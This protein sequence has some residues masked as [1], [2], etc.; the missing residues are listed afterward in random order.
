MHASVVKNS[1]LKRFLPVLIIIAAILIGRGMVLMQSAPAKK[2]RVEPR[3]HVEVLTIQRSP[4]QLTVNSQGTVQA[5]RSIEWASKVAGRVTWVAPE[6]VEGAAV[7]AGQLLLKLDPIDYQ[8]AVAQAQSS[9]ADA[10]LTLTEERSEL[11][12]GNAYRSSNQQADNN[13]L[14]QP[15]LE[16]V[17]ALVKAAQEKLRQA[18][19][20]L[21]ATEI[22]APFT[23]VIDKKQVD[24][25]QYISAGA[26]LFNLLG[27]DIVEVRLPITATDIGFIHLPKAGDNDYAPVQL[28]ASFGHVLQSW[29]G[30]IVRVERRVDSTTRTFFVVAEVDSPYDE[31]LHAVPLSLGLFVDANIQAEKLASGV[32]VRRD[33]IHNNQYVYLVEDEKLK[34]RRVTVARREVDSVVITDG[35]YDGDQLVLT[36]LDLMVDGMPVMVMPTKTPDSVIP[37]AKEPPAMSAGSDNE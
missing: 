4:I 24:L 21:K 29:Q 30:K 9:L 11:R 25:G 33:A 18:Q 23:S 14:R 35:L 26:T 37:E 19:A 31:N 10:N 36:K 16:Q 17:E 13:S 32:R 5:K 12:R 34:Q 8:V 27:T 7:A 22:T 20:D 2:V 28:N 6:F 1:R 3:P 15:K